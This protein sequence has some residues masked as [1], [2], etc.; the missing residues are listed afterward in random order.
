MPKGQHR[1]QVEKFMGAAS[2][3]YV[4]VRVTVHSEVSSFVE[5]T[6][7]FRSVGHFDC[8]C[9]LPTLKGG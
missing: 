4:G 1:E 6:V 2:I 9:K 8:A 3:L 5:G 7:S